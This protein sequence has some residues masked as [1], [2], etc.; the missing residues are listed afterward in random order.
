MLRVMN[1]THDFSYTEG[2]REY[3]FNGIQFWEYCDTKADPPH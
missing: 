3:I 1:E 2:D